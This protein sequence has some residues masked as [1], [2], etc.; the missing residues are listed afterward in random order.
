MFILLI[1]QS[2]KCYKSRSF[3]LYIFRVSQESHGLLKPLSSKVFLGTSDQLCLKFFILNIFQ[4][5]KSVLKFC[6]DCVTLLRNPTSC[7]LKPFSCHRRNT[8]VTNS[9]AKSHRVKLTSKKSSS[10]TSYALTL[11]GPE[12]RVFFLRDKTR[13]SNELLF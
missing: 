11:S 8:A 9:R 3:T 7:E 13:D 1:N 5:L 2:L 6:M 12:S 4:T 10:F